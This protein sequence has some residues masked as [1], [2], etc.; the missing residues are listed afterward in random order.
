MP[1]SGFTF[2]LALK[3]AGAL[4]SVGVPFATVTTLGHDLAGG[5]PGFGAVIAI[6]VSG[7]VDLDCAAGTR[8]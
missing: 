4:A 5:G 8:G 3:D 6:S 2:R 7:F 1:I